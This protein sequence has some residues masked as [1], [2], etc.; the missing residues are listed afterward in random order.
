MKKR[1]NYLITIILGLAI[2]I[3][4]LDYKNFFSLKGNLDIVMALSD[5]FLLPGVIIF[6]LGVMIFVC[7]DG[8]FDIMIYGFKSARE[9]FRK[10]S[11]RDPEFPKT[12]YDYREKYSKIRAP[13]GYL[14][15]IGGVFI[16]L[17]II[18]NTLFYYI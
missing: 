13:F 2:A 1:T 15:I 14:L 16:L 5:C 12:F 9:S 4:I 18:F 10:E 11:N 8:M 7:N 3:A 17:S 6:S